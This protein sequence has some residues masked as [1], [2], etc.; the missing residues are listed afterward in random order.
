MDGGGNRMRDDIERRGADSEHDNEQ[1]Y[2]QSSR[3]DHGHRV[4]TGKFAELSGHHQHRI[5]DQRRLYPRECDDRQRIV[6]L[7]HDRIVDDGRHHGDH[8]GDDGR[9]HGTA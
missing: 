9:L 1:V 8:R 2:G 7:E 3:Q 6:D 5:D 4:S